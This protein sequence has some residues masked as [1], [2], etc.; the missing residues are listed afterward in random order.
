MLPN[1]LLGIGWG[2]EKILAEVFRAIEAFIG[3]QL[4]EI[5][6]EKQNDPR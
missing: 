3:I 5:K 6:I 2:G 4:A 1:R